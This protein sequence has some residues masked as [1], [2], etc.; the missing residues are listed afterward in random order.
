MKESFEAFSPARM[1]KFLL[2]QNEE[3]LKFFVE[4]VTEFFTGDK[5]FPRR[6]FPDKVCCKTGEQLEWIGFT[7][8]HALLQPAHYGNKT[9]DESNCS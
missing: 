9:H 8:M 7:R 5:Y 6:N 3:I 1:T 4:E 2:W